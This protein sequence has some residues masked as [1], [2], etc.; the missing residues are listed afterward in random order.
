MKVHELIDK[1]QKLDPEMKVVVNGYEGGY[2]EV[3]KILMGVRVKHNSKKKTEDLWWLG[4]YEDALST[5]KSESVV[6]LP[7]KS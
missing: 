4:E 2:D 5:E 3:E 1:L 6:V 7:R